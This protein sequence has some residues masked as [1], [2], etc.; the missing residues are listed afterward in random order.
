MPPVSNSEKL[1][2]DAPSKIARLNDLWFM[3]VAL[4]DDT[5]EPGE[6]LK[7]CAQP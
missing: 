7:I 2:P 3:S 1:F 6:G 4:S 5:N